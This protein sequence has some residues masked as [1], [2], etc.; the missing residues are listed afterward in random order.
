MI[1][2]LVNNIT[3]FFSDI[4]DNQFLIFD[5]IKSIVVNAAKFE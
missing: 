4:I 1:V 3:I 5:I 2:V